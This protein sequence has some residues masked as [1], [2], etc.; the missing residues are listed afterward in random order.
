MGVFDGKEVP[1]RLRRLAH[2]VNQTGRLHS[3]TLQQ[4]VR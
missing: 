1:K 3:R 4:K 2:D